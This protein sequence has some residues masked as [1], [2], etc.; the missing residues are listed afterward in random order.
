MIRRPPRSTLF[1]YTTLFRSPVLRCCLFGADPERHDVVTEAVRPWREAV[2]G[3][4][5]PQ[6]LRLA[7]RFPDP[8]DALSPGQSLLAHAF[9]P[10]RRVDPPSLAGLATSC[11]R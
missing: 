3:A 4:P 1:P 10:R 2:V 7:G 5:R 11:A 8:G 6:A 9:F